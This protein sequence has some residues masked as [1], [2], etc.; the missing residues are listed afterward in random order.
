MNIVGEVKD[1]T[2][3]IIDDMVDTA[4]TLTQGVHALLEAGAKRVVAYASHPV[5]SGPA[6]QRIQESRIERCVFT[7]TITLSA[8]AEACKKIEVLTIAP[9]L[10]KAIRRIHLGESVSSLFV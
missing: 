7:D 6:V 9:L 5:L 4:G 1:L 2:A 10:A 8:Q 3:I